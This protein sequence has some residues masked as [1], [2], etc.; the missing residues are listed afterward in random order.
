[1]VARRY[2]ALLAAKRELGPPR[3]LLAPCGQLAG[4][5]PGGAY[6]ATEAE[7]KGRQA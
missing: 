4:R 6:L 2:C 7:E 1:M 3:H 5:T